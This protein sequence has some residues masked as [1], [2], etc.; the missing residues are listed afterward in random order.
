MSKGKLVILS[1]PSGTGKTLFVKNFYQGIKVGNS[2]L[3][4]LQGQREK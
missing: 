4:L 1:A 3:Q 2:Q